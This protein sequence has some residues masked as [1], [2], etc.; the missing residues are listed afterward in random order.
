[1]VLIAVKPGADEDHQE[2]CLSQL[3]DHM[4][5]GLTPLATLKNAHQRR[6]LGV[7]WLSCSLPPSGPLDAQLVLLTN[8]PQH[9]PRAGLGEQ[10]SRVMVAT[11]DSETMRCSPL[12]SIGFQ[13]CV[14]NGFCEA[15]ASPVE[16]E[17]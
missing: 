7:Y 8:N 6:Q 17:L 5:E 3:Y 12:I 14:L 2:K 4:P 10:G 9:V 16:L 15:Q 1:M 11:P 13:S